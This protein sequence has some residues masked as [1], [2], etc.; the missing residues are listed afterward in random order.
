ML[1]EKQAKDTQLFSLEKVETMMRSLS[2]SLDQKIAVAEQGTSVTPT[3]DLAQLKGSI[4]SQLQVSLTR[5]TQILEATD[6]LEKE[7]DWCAM[8]EEGSE[9]QR[10]DMFVQR[11]AK[12]IFDA[13]MLGDLDYID[14][15]IRSY[16]SGS[17]LKTF[18]N[19]TNSAGLTPLHLGVQHEHEQIVQRLLDNGANPSLPDPH[20]NLPIHIAAATGN[21]LI[22]EKLLHKRKEDVNA[23]G[24]NERTPLHEACAHGRQPMA[25]KLLTLGANMSA[26][27]QGEG[28]VTPLHEALLGGHSSIAALLLGK[29]E[30]TVMTRDTQGGRRCT[31]QLLQVVWNAPS[32]S[33]VT[34]T[35]KLRPMMN[36]I[37][38]CVHW[39]NSTKNTVSGYKRMLL[40]LCSTTFWLL[41]RCHWKRSHPMKSRCCERPSMFAA[42]Q[43]ITRK[44]WLTH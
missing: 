18:L 43:L 31:V 35:G 44:S 40:S 9:I 5:C 37:N 27:A 15:L 13:C 1:E 3:T 41:S 4:E 16:L 36:P 12:D 42:K 39:F 22:G 10:E 23:K 8:A 19:Q 20:G 7:R 21:V 6:E 2:L 34:K 30:L 28:A 33:L 17:N 24:E 11:Q 29:K 14:R 25:E 38:V 26:V 32:S